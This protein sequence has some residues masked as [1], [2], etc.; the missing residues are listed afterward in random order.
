MDN[1]VGHHIS[2]DSSKQK[3]NG[4]KKENLPIKIEVGKKKSLVTSLLCY[5][6]YELLSSSC[7][8]L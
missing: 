7:F 1:T 6:L 5:D 3:G 8:V 4:N 2:A